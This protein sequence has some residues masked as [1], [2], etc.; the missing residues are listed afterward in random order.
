MSLQTKVETE[1][2]TSKILDIL[3]HLESIN[4]SLN[5]V[6]VYK[7]NEIKQKKKISHNSE[8]LWGD[9]SDDEEDIV[10]V[11]NNVPNDTYIKR[12][13]DIEECLTNKYNKKDTKTKNLINEILDITDDKMFDTLL[14]SWENI[15]INNSME[16]DKPQQQTTKKFEWG[17]P[18]NQFHTIKKQKQKTNNSI[19]DNRINV[20]T[21]EDFRYYI[22]PE[23]KMKG[24]V[25][26]WDCNNKFCKKFYHIHPDAHCFHTYNGTLCDNVLNCDHIHIQRCLNEIDHFVNGE[27]VEAKECHNK[28]KSCSFL[29]KDDLKDEKEQNNFEETMDEY[30]K[31]KSKQFLQ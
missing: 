6:V 10:N 24:C 22:S 12:S 14:S 27:L 4:L 11:M 19:I 1:T 3:Q 5:D 31:K 29:H 21:L 30:K 9:Y 7:N 16:N 15:K 28:K 13:D 2:Q 20:Y 17:N 18:N 25:R 8:K 26:G 23:K